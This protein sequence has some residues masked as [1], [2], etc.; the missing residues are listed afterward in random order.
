MSADEIE[1]DLSLRLWGNRTAL[2]SFRDRLERIAYPSTGRFA[3]EQ[4]AYLPVESAPET[5]A[6]DPTFDE[7]GSIDGQS[8]VRGSPQLQ[9]A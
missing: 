7:D 6:V 4:R 2:V 9:D 5:E 3:S 1:D 8:V